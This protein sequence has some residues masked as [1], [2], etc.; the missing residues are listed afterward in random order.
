MIFKLINRNQVYNNDI[1]KGKLTDEIIKKLFEQ[2][3]KQ[4][5]T[6]IHHKTI[7]KHMSYRRLIRERNL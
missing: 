4:I 2:W 1:I 5:N 6:V 3:N 7:K